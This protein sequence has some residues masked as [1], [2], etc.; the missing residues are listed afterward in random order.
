MTNQT[1]D[2][3][4][5]KCLSCDKVIENPTEENE[6]G[7]GAFLCKECSEAM[8]SSLDD[9]WRKHSAFLDAALN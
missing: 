1:S 2:A 3:E 8:I 5:C 6:F 7:D 4:V 9:A